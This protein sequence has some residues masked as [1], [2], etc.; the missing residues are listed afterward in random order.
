[1]KDWWEG[2]Q[3]ISGLQGAC[4]PGKSCIH[5]TMTL[6]ETVAVGLG[7]KKKVMVT[8]LDVTKAFDGVWIDG[9]FYQLRNM[10]VLGKV[11]R[12]LYSSYQNF[13]CKVRISGTFSDWYTMECGIH[14]GGVLSLLKYT[15]FIDS[16]LR[17][18]EQSNLGC[19]ISGIPT[20]LIGYADDMASACTAK[21]NGNKSLGLIT[22]YLRQWRYAYNAKKSAILVFRETK[23]EHERGAKYRTF[24]L[25]GE[26]VPEKVVNDHVGIKNCLFND[27]R[28]R[29]EERLSK[30]R[31]AFNAITSVGVQKKGINMK[32]CSILFWSIIVPIVT[33]G[34]ELWVMSGE[35]IEMVRKFQR[36]IGRRCQWFPKCSPNH[37]A[38]ALLGWMSLDRVIQVKKLMF[39]RTV[40]IM[41]DDDVCKRICTTRSRDFVNNLDVGRRNECGSPIFDLLNVSILVGVYD[42]CMQMIANGHF[43]TKE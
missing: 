42:L 10:G 15:A 23:R 26:K 36:E 22:K 20:N 7:S 40:V 31:R 30:G 35:E 3:V 24:M 11:W 34:C 14:Q 32:S 9:L 21:A 17:I 33:Y 8:Y 43:Y 5:S 37:S 6:L 38:Y 29:T 16:L 19:E 27:N 28:P 41:D 39:F 13:Q 12:M 4:R 1:M 25:G 2:E 18:L